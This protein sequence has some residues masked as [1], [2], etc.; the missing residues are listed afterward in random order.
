MKAKLT[1]DPDGYYRI[2][3]GSKILKEGK[4]L[5]AVCNNADGTYWDLGERRKNYMEVVLHD[6]PK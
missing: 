5:R 4:T 2:R 3:Q 6:K 1:L